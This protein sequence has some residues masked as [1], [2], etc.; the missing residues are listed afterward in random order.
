[1]QPGTTVGSGGNNGVVL[2]HLSSVERP[3]RPD[4]YRRLPSLIF[5]LL[6]E[7]SPDDVHRRIAPALRLLVPHDTLRLEGVDPEQ[8]RRAL[9]SGNP[10]ERP[11]PFQ[12]SAGGRRA[13][14][15]PLF[16]HGVLVGELEVSRIG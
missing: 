9:S 5:Q 13:L 1:M 11:E 12:R 6:R 7:E 14:Q 16:A 4:P 15:L 2:R 10:V 3:G 8:L